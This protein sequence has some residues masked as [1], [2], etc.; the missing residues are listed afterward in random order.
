[1]T[2]PSPILNYEDAGPS[3]QTI[4]RQEP[5][6]YQVSVPRISRWRDVG[7]GYLIAAGFFTYQFVVSLHDVVARPSRA[8]GDEWIMPVIFLLPVLVVLGLAWKRYRTRYVFEVTRDALAVRRYVGQRECSSCFYRR[9]LIRSIRKMMGDRKLVISV[10]GHDLIEL[11][12][13]ADVDLVTRVA[14]ALDAAVKKDLEAVDRNSPATISDVGRPVSD[15]TRNR[16]LLILVCVGAACGTAAAALTTIMTGVI[17]F[18]AIA[19]TAGIFMGSQ[20]KDTWL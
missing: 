14:E 20:K 1:M 12:I 13:S 5:G 6:F 17:V 19:M 8:V 3:E 16:N 11:F 15:A 7:K 2:Q 4:F 18:L 10:T 9:D